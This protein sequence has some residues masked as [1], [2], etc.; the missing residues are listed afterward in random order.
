MRF[1]DEAEMVRL[2]GT[3]LFLHQ[4]RE[5]ASLR[6]RQADPQLL[7]AVDICGGDVLLAKSSSYD[8]TMG[9]CHAVNKSIVRM[10]RIWLMFLCV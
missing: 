7:H 2:G 6:R 5:L 1:D 3:L 9:E 10:T 4:L 8:T